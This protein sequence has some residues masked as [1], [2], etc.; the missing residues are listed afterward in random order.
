MLHR[1][2]YHALPSTSNSAQ[3]SHLSQVTNV[4]TFEIILAQPNTRKFS[5]DLGA[6]PELES[7][8]GHEDRADVHDGP[9]DSI[10]PYCLQGRQFSLDVMMP[11][12]WV[13]C[14]GSQ[15]VID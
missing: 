10:L 2:V 9:K 1:L 11:D 5:Q 15:C 13:Y 12:R 6:I 7:A 3:P 14:Q 4:L 8:S